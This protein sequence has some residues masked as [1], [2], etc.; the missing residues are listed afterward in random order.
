MEAVTLQVN[1]SCQ[2][3]TAIVMEA[4][5]PVEQAKA[6]AGMRQLMGTFKLCP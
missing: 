5:G 6:W 4:G 2:I 1:Q 3:V